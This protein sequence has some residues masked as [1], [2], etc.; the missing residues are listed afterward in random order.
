MYGVVVCP[1]CKRARGVDLRHKT[2]TCSCGFEIHVVPARVRGRA[3]TAR[4]LAPLVGRINAQLA[5]GLRTVERDT[6]PTKRARIRNVHARVAAAVPKR[7]D[8]GTRIRIAAI[9]LTRELELF[10]LEDWAEVLRA[11]GIPDAEESLQVL[12][13]TNVVFEP[14]AGFY[15]TVDLTP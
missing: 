3:E 4:E 1:R 15:R 9:E 6:A 13:R 5:G 2:A 10:T 14:K 12:L 7:G 11:L 8:R